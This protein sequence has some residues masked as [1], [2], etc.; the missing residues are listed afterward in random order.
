MKKYI[1]AVLM[2]FAFIGYGQN[3]FVPQPVKAFNF[4]S[5]SAVAATSDDTTGIVKLPSL[6]FEVLTASEVGILWVGGDSVQAAVYIIG[7]NSA[8]TSYTLTYADSI[9]TILSAING[10]AGFL[11]TPYARY[12]PIK[13]SIVDRLPGCTRFKVGTVFTAATGVRATYGRWFLCWR[14]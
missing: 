4:K 13:S 2:L 11:A 7:S 14:Y 5:Y 10:A 1:L 6:P 12:I 8:Q 3:V 9:S